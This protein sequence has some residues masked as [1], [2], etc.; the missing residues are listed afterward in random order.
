MRIQL[1]EL[2]PISRNFFLVR[3]VIDNHVRYSKGTD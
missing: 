3:Q 2:S 1:V